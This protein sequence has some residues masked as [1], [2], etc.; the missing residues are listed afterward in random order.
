MAL[1]LRDIFRDELGLRRCGFG[2]GDPS[3]TGRAPQIAAFNGF[4]LTR[5]WNLYE[6]DLILGV[7]STRAPRLHNR[8]ESASS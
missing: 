1:G 2:K 4:L 3:A 5:K 6:Y 7:L 8:G